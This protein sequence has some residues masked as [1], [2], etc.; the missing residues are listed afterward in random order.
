M[1]TWLLRIRFNRHTIPLVALTES[2]S[3]P[4]SARTSCRHP[5]GVPTRLCVSALIEWVKPGLKPDTCRGG[6]TLASV[7]ERM[8][9][10]EQLRVPFYAEEPSWARCPQVPGT[11]MRSGC[12]RGSHPNLLLHQIRTWLL[13]VSTFPKLPHGKLWPQLLLSAFSHQLEHGT[14]GLPVANPRDVKRC[15][16]R[17]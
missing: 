7:T 10:P 6:T 1:H 13:S 11:V 15:L 8:E 12:R 3:V 2:V 16:F 5:L 4:I 14:T 17:D 9:R